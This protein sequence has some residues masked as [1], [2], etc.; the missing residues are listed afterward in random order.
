MPGEIVHFEIPAD[1]AEKG[2]EFWSGLLAHR[3]TRVAEA[4]PTRPRTELGERAGARE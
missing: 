2:R 1:D 3:D 4:R